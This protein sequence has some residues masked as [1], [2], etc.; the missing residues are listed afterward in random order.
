[1]EERI[2][3]PEVRLPDGRYWILGGQE[4]EETS[5]HYIDGEFVPGP[6]LPSDGSNSHPCAVQVTEDLTFFGN[7]KGYLYSASAN[8]FVETADPML[9]YAYPSMC[10][11]VTDPADGKRYVIVAG[12]YDADGVFAKTQVYDVEASTYI[13][14]RIRIQW[15]RG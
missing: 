7:R 8:E 3:A 15:W 13:Y 12:G 6:A 5:E 4:S 2:Y 10:G 11:A 1:M 9:W 14:L